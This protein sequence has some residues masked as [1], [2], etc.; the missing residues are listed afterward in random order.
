[1]P[2][3]I[4]GGTG[5]IG[6]RLVGHW[7]DQK[8]EVIV[9]GRNVDY[10]NNVFSSKVKA[11]TWNDLTPDVF[12]SAELV[13]N[14]A[15]ASIGEKR[16]TEKRKQEILHSRI[17]STQKIAG[18]LA[19]LGERSPPLFNASAIGVYGLQKQMANQLPSAFTEDTPIDVHQ[20]PDFL[21]QVAR[22]WENATRLAVQQHVRVIYLRF[23]VVLAK[24]GGALP[25]LV[26]P[27]KF[28][29][30]GRLGRGN[31]PFSWIAID[32]LIKAIDFLIAH[33]ELSGPFNL[34]APQ[35]VMQKELAREVGKRLDRPS[36]FVMPAFI[37]KILLGKQLAQELLLE[38]QHVKPKRLQELGFQFEFGR[39]SEALQH[40]LP[41]N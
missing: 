12:A 14:L 26:Q 30:G 9:I 31:Q 33:P 11:L 15:G 2:R 38:G 17:F 40:I 19:Q 1:M 28:F 27:F 39:L 20:F 10:I 4:S 22:E 3:I 32:D 35:C 7:L 16:W 5:L 41:A 25:Q 13:V 23:G 29:V 34:V 36:F 24:E 37:L 18:Y 8:H 6:K 21:S